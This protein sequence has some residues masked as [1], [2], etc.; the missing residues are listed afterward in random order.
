MNK[1]CFFFYESDKLN[2]IKYNHVLQEIHYH[3]E[4]YISSNISVGINKA[5]E[6]IMILL[7]YFL[8]QTLAEIAPVVYEWLDNANKF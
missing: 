7:L 4:N 5:V 3:L 2:T 8:C 1:K 6:Q